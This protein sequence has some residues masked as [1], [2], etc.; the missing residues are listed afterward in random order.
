[1]LFDGPPSEF[2]K[3]CEMTHAG[4]IKALEDK[5]VAYEALIKSQDAIIVIYGAL[6]KKSQLLIQSLKVQLLRKGGL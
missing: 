4:Y 5:I 6:D 1:M 2:C 3:L